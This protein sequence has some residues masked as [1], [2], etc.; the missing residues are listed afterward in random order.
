MDFQPSRYGPRIAEILALDGNGNRLMPLAGGSCSSKEAARL[1]RE[2]ACREDLRRAHAPEA[3][4]AGL[5]LYFSCM[6]ESHEVSQAVKS[7]EGPLWHAILHRQEPDAWNAKYWF[8]QAG[9]H[10]FFVPLRAEAAEISAREGG[11][12]AIPDPW[13]PY[14]FVDLCDSL[15]SHP[16]D[17]RYA[18]AQRI[19]TAEWQC[20][21]DFCALPR[22]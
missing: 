9:K 21:F 3:A 14:W 11:L 10:P 2:G 13:D 20:L 18:L 6:D 5:W 19:Q 12:L 16:H 1:L 8:R 17:P 22:R 15:R 4:M 7:P